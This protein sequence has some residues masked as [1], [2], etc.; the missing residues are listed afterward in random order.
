MRLVDRT[1][2]LAGYQ[3]K[4]VN[5]RVVGCDTLGDFLKKHLDHFEMHL[6]FKKDLI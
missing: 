4:Q 6:I 1:C 5:F 3:S 2:L